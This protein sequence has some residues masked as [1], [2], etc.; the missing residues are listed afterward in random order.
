MQHKVLYMYYTAFTETFTLISFYPLWIGLSIS[1]L[2]ISCALPLF[3]RYLNEDQEFTART[4]KQG[5]GL[6]LGYRTLRCYHCKSF[7]RKRRGRPRKYQV[8]DRER[9]C[10]CVWERERERERERSNQSS[11]EDRWS[12]LVNFS[13]SFRIPVLLREFSEIFK[14]ST[15]L[16]AY[17]YHFWCPKNSS[18]DFSPCYSSTATNQQYHH[19]RLTLLHLP[20]TLCHP[21]NSKIFH[22]SSPQLY[23]LSLSAFCVAA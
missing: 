15:Y 3:G 8:T 10:V 2:L 1:K 14:F 11:S 16:F 21:H 5:L 12:N 4:V 13:L 7:V 18:S 17:Q 19:I 9:V 6:G 20:V 22:L 23:T